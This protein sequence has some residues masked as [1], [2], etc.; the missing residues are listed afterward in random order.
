MK[1]QHDASVKLL[2]LLLL[3]ELLK[4]FKFL[5]YQKGI[6]T[7]TL[8]PSLNGNTFFDNGYKQI[9]NSPGQAQ[10]N[11]LVPS[12]FIAFSSP[13]TI[14]F[15]SC[16]QNNGFSIMKSSSHPPAVQQKNTVN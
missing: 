8:T 12:L 14:P 16:D 10:G 7:E 13:N 6:A 9:H 4:N 5:V 1:W 11:C 2:D 15:R 3:K